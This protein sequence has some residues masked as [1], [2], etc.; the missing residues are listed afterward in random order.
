MGTRGPAPKHS[1]EV[2][3]NHRR[4]AEADVTKGQA[5][6]VTKP[7]ADP[8]WAPFAKYVF[9]A[10]GKS[11]MTDFAQN[12]D[13]A[14]VWLLAENVD[15][16]LKSGRRSAMA[17]AEIRQLMSSLAYTEADRRRAGIELEE[18]T[19]ARVDKGAEGVNAARDRLRRKVN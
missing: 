12:T 3:G 4:N 8:D 2:K 6:K 7:K 11:G 10:F 5:R 19:E 18:P 9:D 15:D 13:W 14:A 16:Y 1:S 17:M